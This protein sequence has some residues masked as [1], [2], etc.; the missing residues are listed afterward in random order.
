MNMT[1][2]DK[3]PDD[4]PCAWQDKH[5]DCWYEMPDSK[6][7]CKGKCQFYEYTGD[8]INKDTKESELWNMPSIKKM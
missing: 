2:L 4:K 8:Y 7:S 3:V 5:N 1:P 6:F